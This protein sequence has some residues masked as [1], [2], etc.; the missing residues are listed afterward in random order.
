MFAKLSILGVCGVSTTP[1]VMSLFIQWNCNVKVYANLLT[2]K[3]EIFILWAPSEGW[4]KV[5]SLALQQH[6]EWA[7]PTGMKQSYVLIQF[8]ILIYDLFSYLNVFTFFTAHYFHCHCAK[9]EVSSFQRFWSHLLKKHFMSLYF[10]SNV[11]SAFH[12]RN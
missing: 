1:A 12:F 11:P 9:H 10:F 3:S 4:K 8:L 6:S 5:R 7:L 2:E